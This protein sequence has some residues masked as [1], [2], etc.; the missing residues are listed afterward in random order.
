MLSGTITA[1]TP[2]KNAHAA[3]HPA[4]TSSSVIENVR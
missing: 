4:I 2:P 1:N 3:S